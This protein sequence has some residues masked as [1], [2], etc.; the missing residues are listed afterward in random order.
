MSSVAQTL[1]VRRLTEVTRRTFRSLRVRNYRAW[2]IGQTV[3]MS[4][5]WMQTVAQGWLV[6]SLTHNALYLG[7]TAALQFLPILVFGTY[8]GLISDRLDKRHVLMATQ[9]L[10]MVQ[11][12]RDVPGR[13]HRRG[14]AVDDL[15]PGAGHGGHQRVRQPRQA[16]LRRRHGGAG[17]PHQRR[18]SEQ[19]RRQL[20]ADRRAGRRRGAHLAFRALVDVRAERGVVHGGARGAA[21]DAPGGAAPRP[22]RAPRARAGARRHALRVERVGAARPA[23]DDGRHGHALVQLHR[24]PAAVRQRRVPPRRRHAGRAH[25]GHGHRRPGRRPRG[26][27]PAPPELPAAHRHGVRLRRA[28][29]G[30]RAG[31]HA[32]AGPGVPRAHGRRRRRLHRP[33]QLPAAAALVRADAGPCDGAVGHRLPGLDAHRGAADRAGGRARRRPGV[34]GHGRP[35]RRCSPRSAAR[36]PCGASA[37]RS[38]PSRAHRPPDRTPQARSRSFAAQRCG[39]GDDVCAAVCG[40]GRCSLRRPPLFCPA[41]R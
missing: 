24:D 41:P 17:G 28:C 11:A 6:Y 23:A 21:R 4:G 18:R 10:F 19:R 39:A 30:R 14:P 12:S 35:R 34:A 29:P 1:P 15:G 8:G 32:A 20:L 16:E 40:G 31:A 38:V 7:L 22:A 25:H 27:L 37:A 13:G 33:G 3:S 36:S 9:T 2:F 26:R 5:T